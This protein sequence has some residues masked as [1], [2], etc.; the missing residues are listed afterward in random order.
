MSV[1]LLLTATGTGDLR[2]SVEEWLTAYCEQDPECAVTPTADQLLLDIHPAADPVE[3]SFVERGTMVVTATTATARPGYHLF[4]CDLLHQLGEA[5]GLTWDDANDD[6]CLDDTGYFHSGDRAAPAQRMNEWLATLTPEDLRLLPLGPREQ[7]GPEQFPW[8]GED[9]DATYYLNRALTLMWQSVRWRAP[10]TDDERAVDEAVLIHLQTAYDLDPTLDFP[11]AEWHELAAYVE[12]EPP[13]IP[14]SGAEPSIGYLRKWLNVHVKSNWTVRIPGAFATQFEGDT[15]TAFDHDTTVEITIF[16]F[17]KKTPEQI[18]GEA[19]QRE[20]DEELEIGPHDR[21]ATEE[22]VEEDECHALNGLIAI[23]ER[24]CVVNI[25]F[26]ATSEE[27][28]SLRDQALAI[29]QSIQA[30]TA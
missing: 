27:D 16:P 17:D 19:F 25:Y 20:R 8:P 6:T 12:A 11:A 4:V 15:W 29:W 14:D 24:L 13:P 3:F 9:R 23:P 28:A 26:A 2:P 18:L 5:A 30:H 22:Y 7:A 1:G 10:L 21:R